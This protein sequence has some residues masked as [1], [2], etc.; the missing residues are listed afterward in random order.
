MEYA[1]GCDMGGSFVKVGTLNR[2]GDILSRQTIS[3]PNIPS[4]EDLGDWISEILLKIYEENSQKGVKPAGAGIGVPGPLR[5]PE[6][7]LY[8]PPNLH[9]KG[10]IPFGKL[11][12]KRLPFP[13]FLDSDAAVQTLRKVWRGLGIGLKNFLYI[14]LGTGIGGGIV[15]DSKIFHGADGMAGKIGHLTVDYNGRKCLCGARG[16]LET[17][18]SASGIKRTVFK[19]LGD[20]IDDSPLRALSFNELTAADV[21]EAAKKG[22]K[23]ALAA[24]EHTGRMLGYKLAD[25]V[26]HTNPEAIFLFGGLTLSGDLIFEPTR[27]HMEQNLL[28]IYKGKVKLL[29]SRLNTQNA[30]VLGASA[31]VWNHRSEIR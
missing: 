28:E 9:F 3:L 27:R 7:T 14:A 24:F 25:V 21:S 31:L 8:D 6:G 2:E 16:C 10:E 15:T 26:A 4:P 22:D 5:Y 29:P 11:V 13:V 17:Y 23:V 30:A 19:L 1:I 20:M 18:V 12:K